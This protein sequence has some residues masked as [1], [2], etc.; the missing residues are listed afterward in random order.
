MAATSKY[1]VFISYSRGL[2]TR[3]ATALQRGLHRFAKP[4][5]RAR[6]VR[7]F[8]DDSALSANPNTANL[9]DHLISWV[10]ATCRPGEAA[11]G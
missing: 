2:D 3:V 7:V 5:Y 9:R 6:A 1:A 8:R 4:W 11:Y 10:H